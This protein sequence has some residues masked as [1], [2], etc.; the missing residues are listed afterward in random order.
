MIR[1]MQSADLDRVA[2]IWL[3]TNRTAHAFVPA[4]YWEERYEAVKEMISQAEVYVYEDRAGVQGF[5]GLIGNHVAGIFVRAGA[6][7]GGIGAQ[8][9]DV[10]KGIKTQLSLSVYQKNPRAIRFYRR[11]GFRVQCEGTDEDT[12]EAE[13][14]MVWNR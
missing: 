6:Q 7:S 14:L 13:Y 4:R 3:E 1:T 2:E 9:L 12:G 8:L 5:V 10:V 11:E